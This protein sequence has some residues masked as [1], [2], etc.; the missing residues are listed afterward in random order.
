M[1]Y[2]KS[3]EELH[4]KVIP[5]LP[6]RAVFT[7]NL[8][9]GRQDL[10]TFEAR[11]SVDHQSK[12]SSTGETRGVEF[13]LTRSGNMDFRVQGLPHSIVQKQDDVRKETVKK[14]IHQPETSESRV[15]DGRPRSETKLLV[16]EKSEELIRSMGNTEYLGMCEI[17]SEVQ[18]LVC[19][20]YWRKGIVCCICGKCLQPSPKNRRLNRD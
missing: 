10:S 5:R 6:Q 17:T 11:T 13:E 7:P 12:E 16:S 1:E 9:H 20:L 19:L 14:L 2:M 4:N 15:A 3:G 18:C 8:S